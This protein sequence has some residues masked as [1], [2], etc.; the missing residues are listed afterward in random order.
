MH[1]FGHYVDSHHWG[2]SYLFSIGI[3]SLGSATIARFT[4]HRHSHFWSEK[5]ANRRA[6]RH[7]RDYYGLQNWQEL[8]DG[9]HTFTDYPK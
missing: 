6:W 2:P 8:A 4:N 9:I 1:E 3:P 7:F 5:R